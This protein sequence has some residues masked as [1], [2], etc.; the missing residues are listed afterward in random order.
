M[1]GSILRQTIKSSF[2]KTLYQPQAL[3]FATNSK[4]KE[5]NEEDDP[6]AVVRPHLCADYHR[7]LEG[8]DLYVK[9]KLFDDPDYFKNLA[10]GQSP[11]H[12]FIGCADSR[13]PPNE[14]TKTNPGELF[15]HR[16]IA[17]L[18]VPTDFNINSVIQ[19][20]IE[21]LG[22]K[23]IIVMGHTGCGGVKAALDPKYHGMID[24]WLNP[25]REVHYDNR[26]E[27]DKITDHD[28]KVRRLTEL[29]IKR[30]VLNLCKN[31]FVQ[32]AWSRGENLGVHGWLCEVETGRIIDLLIDEQEWRDIEGYFKL[33]F[34]KKDKVKPN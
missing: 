17:N 16:N 10:K 23:D 6:P 27:L 20:A 18:V 13:V 33:Q 32:K 22:V 12:L 4:P 30:Q 11:K 34:A 14:L 24:Q 8:N 7:L 2:R 21:G 29:T 5:N 1:L 9:Q 31:Q 28:Q 15:I 25:I 26:E 19:F 3:N